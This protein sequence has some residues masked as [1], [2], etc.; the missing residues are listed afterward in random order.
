M[1]DGGDEVGVLAGQDGAGVEEEA[2]AVD[3]GDD[4][5]VAVAECGGG[6]EGVDVLGAPAVGGACFTG[7]GA[8]ADGG[9]VGVDFAER[10]GGGPVDGAF[11]DFVL[12]GG[13]HLPDGDVAFGVACEVGLEGGDE[14][15]E[16]CLVG[17]EDAHEWV[18]AEGGDGGFAADDDASLGAA[19]EFVAAEHDEV[20]A[21]GD[22]IL[23]GGF[24]GEVVLG[25]VEQAAAAD[26]VDQER[27]G[28]AGVVGG[29]AEFLEGRCFGEADDAE[30]AG[31]DAEDGGGVGGCGVG[32][33]VG[34]GAVGGADFDEAGA[35]LSED[36]WDAEAA[37]DFDGLAAADDDFAVL[38]VGG[39]C[40]EECGGVVVD[41]EG[42]FCA[43]EGAEEPVGVMVAGA[44]G[45]GGEVEFEV[46]V[47]GGDFGHGLDGGVAEGGA[48]EVGVD[49]D[50]GGVDDGA[51]RAF[52]GGAEEAGGGAG[53]FGG[54]GGFGVAGCAVAEDAA[55]FGDFGADG[56]DDE[57]AGH[58]V[59]GAFEGGLGEDGVDGG[60]GAERGAGCCGCCVGRHLML[61][62]GRIGRAAGGWADCR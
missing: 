44:A 38:G 11:G 22:G 24:G 62:G 29:G 2:S 33:V 8:A 61:R 39:E 46:G 20:G 5:R 58:C 54:A 41:D 53:D 48:A 6:G 17:A 31:V 30:V 27:A 26:V 36:V 1:A 12:V 3:A 49:D 25:G 55:G 43:G 15:G 10:G 60:E 57:V 28:L 34:A 50:A 16:G 7:E 13:D 21:G 47:A 23:G 9:F 45:S 40:E 14:A 19:E 4:G 18:A 32:V 51:E 37:A 42:G 56:V 35:G 59:E 52:G